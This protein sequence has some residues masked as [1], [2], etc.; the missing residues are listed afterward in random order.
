MVN[1]TDVNDQRPIFEQSLLSILASEG[2]S[3]PD[4]PRRLAF[5]RFS[6][7]DTLPE[8]TNSTISVLS[9]STVGSQLTG[10][11]WHHTYWHIY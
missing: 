5:F 4:Q 11:F 3:L 7:D 10:M 1:L 9:V 8:N 2:S 6:D